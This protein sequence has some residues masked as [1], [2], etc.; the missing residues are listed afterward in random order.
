MRLT[1]RQK[2]LQEC[3]TKILDDFKQFPNLDL[4]ECVITDCY[5]LSNFKKIIH[6][7][8][9]K[10]NQDFENACESS[11]HLAIRNIFDICLEKDIHST[12]FGYEIF[13]PSNHFRLDKTLQ[14]VL[15]TIRKCLEKLDKKISAIF[16]K[17]RHC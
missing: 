3:A 9:P 1:F 15:R 10:Y 7:V 6:V 8:L 13:L 14:I 2:T 5:S 4:S 12:C 17:K 16:L 11:L